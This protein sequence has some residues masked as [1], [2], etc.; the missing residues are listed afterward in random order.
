MLNGNLSV[1]GR[2][3]KSCS[4]ICS[5]IIS[6]S[7]TA[8]NENAKRF[9][10]NKVRENVYKTSRILGL[11]IHQI[12][13][14]RGL[15]MSKAKSL[16]LFPSRSCTSAHLWA[17][18]W[19]S[20]ESVWDESLRRHY[21]SSLSSTGSDRKKR[22][23]VDWSLCTWQSQRQSVLHQDSTHWS[24]SVLQHTAGSVLYTTQTHHW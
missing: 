17:A 20:Q 22:N 4:L 16:P 7:F 23:S 12:S 10:K 2:T 1:R 21:Q 18:G 3:L 11:K 6:S 5:R 14:K 9:V 15:N 13:D 24:Q 19:C 8:S